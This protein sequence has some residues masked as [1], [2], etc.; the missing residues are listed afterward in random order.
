MAAVIISLSRPAG[1]LGPFQRP[2]TLG[3]TRYRL[4]VYPSARPGGGL[5]ASLLDVTGVALVSSFR[6]LV[7]VDDLLEPHRAR[8]TDLPPG[9]LYVRATADPQPADLSRG[10]FELVYEE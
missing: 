1:A 3:R 10:T 8:V 2:V 6:L 7:G 5:W 9:R 4:Q